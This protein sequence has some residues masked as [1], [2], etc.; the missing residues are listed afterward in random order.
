MSII[1]YPPPQAIK[2]KLRCKFSLPGIHYNCR[3][4]GKYI[5]GGKGY[6]AAH[7]DAVWRFKNPVYGQQHDWHLHVNQ[8][9]GE[10]W[11]YETCRRCGDIRQ[12]EG[13]AQGPC[14]GHMPR[15][16]LRAN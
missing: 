10:T 14:K 1:P 5:L 12:R 7:Y 6:C 11:P 8:Y 16:E 3:A 9:T 13:L 2:T 15:I 4:V